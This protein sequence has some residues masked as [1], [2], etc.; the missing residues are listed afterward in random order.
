MSSDTAITAFAPAGMVTPFEAGTASFTVAVNLSPTLFV[1]VQTRS[2]DV[3]FIA[4][5]VATVPTAASL[6]VAPRVTVLP[7][8][9]VVTAGGADAAAG[10]PLG[11]ALE[12]VCAGVL[13]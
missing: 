12:C 8:A 6:P 9:V 11:R 5:P 7:L 2:V 1:F 10:V 13:R 3:R 4:V